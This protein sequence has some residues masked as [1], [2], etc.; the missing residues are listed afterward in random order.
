MICLS[1]VVE[2]DNIVEIE[3]TEQVSAYVLSN[4]EIVDVAKAKVSSSKS[5]SKKVSNAIDIDEDDWGEHYASGRVYRPPLLLRNLKQFSIDNLYHFRCINQIS[6]DACSG[7]NIVTVDDRG[8]PVSEDKQKRNW[9]TKNN[10]LYTFFEDS[11]G[12]D[13][14]IEGAR[15][16]LINYLTYGIVFVE[17]IRNKKGEISKFKLL[18]TETCRIARHLNLP[19][20]DDTDQKF[21]VQVVNNHERVFKI[22][23]GEKPDILEPHTRKPMTE[24]LYLRNYHVMGGKYG[25]P[26]W[27]PALKAMIGNDKVAEYNITFFNNEAV[28]RFAVIV[29]G[30]KL[31]DETKR[32][33]KSYF[34]NDLK[35]VQNA[36]KTLVLSTPKGA[37]IKLVPLAV[38]MKDGG[39]RYYRKDNR[40]EIISAHG[41][42]PHRIQ[43]YDSGSIASL[44]PST[45]LSLD[46]AYKY[47]TL[48]PIQQKLASAFNKIIRL[49][50]GIK[51][52]QVIFDELDIG[53]EAERANILKIIAAAHEKYY[54]MGTMTPDEIR[55]DNKL[56]KFAD[57]PEVED[58]VKEWAK[59]PK[60]IYL[61]RQAQQQAQMEGL[62]AQ[63]AGGQ[64]INE[65]SNEFD[66]KSKEETESTLDD[67]QIDSLMMKSSSIQ[68]FDII[69]KVDS[70]LS[71]ISDLEQIV[72]D[73]LEDGGSTQ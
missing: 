60:P 7:W 6:I 40:D 12:L 67:K 51:D 41:V 30:S 29:Q 26:N 22:F 28:P 32:T 57:I 71:R 56:R 19:G 33:I 48:K 10:K 45:I 8:N 39:F 21:V 27:V 5:K 18:P 4:G 13:G 47:S 42:P 43:V 16:V 31:D 69:Q 2:K 15:D 24:V 64:N 49:S 44:S 50:F 62:Q 14:F 70:A 61:I 20:V 65:T 9:S 25:V 35:G 58:D 52:K 3:E 11:F 63:V 46:K 59:T 37:E 34:K 73:H 54:N 17:I 55:E 53:E 36:H 66:D 72:E 68:L 23:D 1:D 38:E